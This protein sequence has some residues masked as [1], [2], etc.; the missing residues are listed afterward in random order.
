MIATYVSLLNGFPVFD[1][2]IVELG[3]A[4]VLTFCFGIAVHEFN[5]GSGRRIAVAEAG[6]ENAGVTAG[7]VFIALGQN[8]EEFSDLRR[9]PQD[10]YRLT[11]FGLP[12]VI[13][14]ST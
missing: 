11:P 13:S 6:L 3:R 12:R 14:F 1:D 9:I 7:A 5:D 4:G 2:F 8:I 10:R